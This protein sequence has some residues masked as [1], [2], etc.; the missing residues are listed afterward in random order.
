MAKGAIKKAEGALKGFINA[1]DIKTRIKSVRKQCSLMKY[2]EL[3][4][5]DVKL[6]ERDELIERVN[7]I[8]DDLYRK[9][10]RLDREHGRM[11]GLWCAQ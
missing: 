8:I 2:K 9:Y 5:L 10:D 11:M 6:R 1:V 3:D 7:S 4:L